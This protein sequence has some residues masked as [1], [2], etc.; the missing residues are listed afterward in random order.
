[1]SDPIVPVVAVVQARPEAARTVRAIWDAGEAA[2]VLDPAA[3]AAVW[4]RVLEAVRPTHLVDADGRRVLSDGIGT[5]E[6]VAAIVTTSGTTAVPKAV[7][8]TTGGMTTIG[9][10]FASALEIR[11]DDRWLVCLPLHHVAGLAILARART[12][13]TPVTV[14]PG[15]DVDAVVA[16]A[17]GAGRDADGVTV[18]SVVPTMLQ[19]M[20]DADA[21]VDRF[22]WIVTGG[23]RTPPA[24]RRRAEEAGG[25]PVD[26]YGLSE[27]W[28]GV[29]V[30]GR[31]IDGVEVALVDDEI[32]VR[33]EPIMRGYRL[34]P[35]ATAA[36]L[37]E[38]HGGGGRWFRTGDV[39]A[40]DDAGRITVVDRR[41]DLVVTG[42][43]NVSPT[44]VESVLASHPDV[45]D[46][47]VAG[48]PDPEWGERVVAYVV[49]VTARAPSVDDLRA[50]GRGLLTGPQLPRAVVVVPEIPRTPG[51]KVLRRELAPDR[52]RPAP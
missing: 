37:V 46:I 8:L 45:A 21:P 38:R 1:M 2:C 18:V 36:A 31:P 29:V 51:G 47:A 41:R 26:A 17:R 27:T 23:A 7:E 25:R 14:H 9:R 11:D 13:G 12:T 19:R 24:L 20:L 43:V 10:G 4:A 49:P 33:G 30:D 6:G 32:L 34:D 44:A 50:F 52:S 42:G 16:S 28:G 15:F 5:F 40:R 3:P 39:G 35:E 48:E 22:R